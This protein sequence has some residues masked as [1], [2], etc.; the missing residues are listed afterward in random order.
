MFV[1]DL[2]VSN[3]KVDYGGTFTTIDTQPLS[4]KFKQNIKKLGN[5]GLFFVYFRSFS[6]KQYYFYNKSM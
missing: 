6:N 3:F 2:I 1:D 4:N 5:N